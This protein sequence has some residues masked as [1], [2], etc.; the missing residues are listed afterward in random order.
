MSVDFSLRVKL[1]NI[2]FRIYKIIL[3]ENHMLNFLLT[4]F[5]YK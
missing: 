1:K 4:L 5:V 2:Y 3:K